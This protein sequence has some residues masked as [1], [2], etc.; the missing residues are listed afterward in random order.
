L[1]IGVYPGSFDPVT[2]GH[3]DIVERATKMFDQVIMA[4]INNPRK[5]SLFSAEERVQMLSEAT[6]SNPRIKVDS[7]TGLLMD[8]VTSKEAL[9]VIRGL[10]AVSDFDYEMQMAL[11]NN[12]LCPNVETIFIISSPQYIYLSSSNIKE[13]AMLGGCVKG[14]VPGCVERKLMEKANL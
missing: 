7:F 10:R 12:K 1:K 11:M 5:R 3:L 4:V 13:V 6:C 14:L 9:A 8:Y 2:N